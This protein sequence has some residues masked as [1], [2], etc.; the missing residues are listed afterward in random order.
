VAQPFSICGYTI[1][2]ELGRGTTGIVYKAR[3]GILKPDRLVALKIPSLGPPSEQPKRL[4]SFHREFHALA[5]LTHEPDPAF[6]TLFD[7]GHDNA[8]EHYLAREFV[9]GSTLERRATGGALGLREGIRILA[10][11]AGAVR[12]LHDRGI[13]HRNLQPSNVLVGR[14]GTAKLIGFGLVWAL[15]GSDKLPPGLS[16][17]SAEV[18]VRALRKMLSWLCATLRLPVPASLAAIRQFVSAPGA[19]P[20][21]EAL[22][23]YLQ[24]GKT[25]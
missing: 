24:G 18:D 12:E 9:D 7:V 20:F 22:R 6:P 15:A 14:D 11:V 1:L 10:T 23:S 21:E 5:M 2:A 16:G 25:A 4:A 17:E 19:A 3:H 8:G 13:A